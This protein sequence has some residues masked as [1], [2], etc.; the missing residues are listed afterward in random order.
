MFNVK[1]TRLDLSRLMAA[2]PLTHILFPPTWTIFCQTPP[3]GALFCPVGT[4]PVLPVPTCPVLS[5][6]PRFISVAQCY[7]SFSMP[8]F[9]GYDRRTKLSRWGE[10]GSAAFAGALAY[11]K[12][13]IVPPVLNYLHGRYKRATMPAKRSKGRVSSRRMSKRRFSG[14]RSSKR[15]GKAGVGRRRGLRF[16]S[17]GA[18]NKALNTNVARN[19]VR[20]LRL[21]KNLGDIELNEG[22]LTQNNFRYVCQLAHWTT[23][24]TRVI[25]AYEEFKFKDVQFVLVPRTIKASDMNITVKAN[26]IPYL[27]VRQVEPISGA[28]LLLAPD[29]VRRT[30]GFR[31]LPLGTKKRIVHNVK[32][33]IVTQ[34]NVT[35]PSVGTAIDSHMAMP[36]LKVD[37]ETKLLD[38][39]AIEI[40]KPEIET[41]N[42]KSIRFDVMVYAT[43]MLRGNNE[44]LI[45]PY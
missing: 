24:W 6:R 45:T 3:P 22:T 33:S 19:D 27:A 30:P 14:R 20:S 43:L 12:Y 40:R 42:G 26:E 17:R 16:T 7:W 4:A 35:T 28:I 1:Q 2:G 31:F 23:S 38:F 41:L 8:D 36:W 5:A 34:I 10:I 21:V 37:T 11:S 32:P 18:K 13:A 44:E 39:A 25:E 9:F 15:F 29:K